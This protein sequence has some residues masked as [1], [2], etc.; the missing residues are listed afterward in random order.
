MAAIDLTNKRFERLLV[1]SRNGN[2]SDGSALWKCICDCGSERT[3][4]GTA[5]RAG[6]HKSCGCSSPR[7]TSERCTTHGMVKTKT[8]KTWLGMLS[9]CS[10]KSKG[11]TRKNYWSKGIRVC[12]RWKTFENFLQDMGETP[13]GLTL[14]RIDGNGNY[15]KGNCRWATDK[16]QANNTSA[17]LLITHIGKTQTLAMWADDIGIKANTLLYRIRREIP[18]ERAMQ[19][20]IGH[21][22]SIEAKERERPCAHC[23]SVFLPR[24][25]QVRSGTGLFCSQACN[26]ASRKNR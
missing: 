24:P 4:A 22:K 20:K 5:L 18:L 1:L 9:R 15:E 16:E 10:E 26:G 3:I 25:A 17:N 13:D 11:K 12:E 23:G 21:I 14:D 8:Y 19:K 2:T 7:F 6:R